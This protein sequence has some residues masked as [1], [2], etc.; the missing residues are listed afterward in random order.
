MG[1]DTYL[2]FKGLPASG[3]T[4]A[5]EMAKQLAYRAVMVSGITFTAIV[6]INHIY[7]ASLLIDEIDTK[8]DE[9]TEVGRGYV[10]FL[11]IWL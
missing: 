5:M 4:R 10:D 7:N 6:R 8:L 11:K 1:Y 3:K 9:R 2:H